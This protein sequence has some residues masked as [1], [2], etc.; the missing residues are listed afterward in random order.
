MPKVVPFKGHFENA[1]AFL[2]NIAEQVTPGTIV[3]VY[4][5]DPGQGDPMKNDGQV[6]GFG[7]CN[8]RQSHM[9]LI[10]A[11]AIKVAAMDPGER[12]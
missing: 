4:T 11:D 12:R 8:A 3:V 1:K 5:F 2:H 7:Q 10:G 9:A 6:L